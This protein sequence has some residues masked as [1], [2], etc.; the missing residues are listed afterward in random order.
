MRVRI[1]IGA[2]LAAVLGSLVVPAVA[3]PTVPAACVYVFVSEG[4]YVQIG[5]APNGP[6]SCIQ[7]P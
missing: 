2:A 4:F 1:L 3:E 6:E 7:V 5:S